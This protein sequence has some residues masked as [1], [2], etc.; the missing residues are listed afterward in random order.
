LSIGDV[1]GGAIPVTFC[2]TGKGTTYTPG[3]AKAVADINE[4]TA[5]L[6]KTGAVRMT[7]GGWHN[8]VVTYTKTPPPVNGMSPPQAVMYIDGA[9]VAS[10]DPPVMA[11]GHNAPFPQP[12]ASNTTVIGKGFKGKLDD[13]RLYNVALT[14]D[15][16]TELAWGCKPA[17]FDPK[18]GKV[19]IP[20]VVEYSV[21]GLM[22]IAGA[23]T[24]DLMA[25]PP[26][27]PVTSAGDVVVG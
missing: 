19:S 20:C 4:R 25:L 14:P 10:S 16:I 9:R 23:W 22:V 11:V 8:I 18:T 1:A 24:A 21:S 5:C 17:T 12:K 13:V 26:A 2:A 15:D 27:K 7:T 6:P 3:T